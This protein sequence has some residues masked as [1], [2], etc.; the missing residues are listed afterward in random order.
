MKQT[1]MVTG[2]AG[3]V[4]SALCR[5]LRGAG[6]AVVAVVRSAQDGAHALGSFDAGTDFSGVLAGVDTVVHLA[7]RVHVMNDSEA[8]QLGAYRAA[9]VDT[10]LALARQA[11]ACGVRRFVFASSLKVNGEASPLRPFGAA[12]APAPADPYGQSK[13]E[14]ELGLRALAAAS[15]MELVIVRPPLVYGPGVKANF[16]RLME[17]VRRGLPLPLASV[18]N[19]RSMVALDN[20]VDLLLVCCSHPQAPGHT[21]LVS[22]GHDLSSAELVRLIAAAMGRPAR[23]LPVPPALLRAGAAVL[24]KAAL[25]Q[26]LLDSLQVDIDA[27][28]STLGWTPP[29][30][31]EEGVRRCVDYFLKSRQEE[32]R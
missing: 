29:L 17:L 1:V 19:R 24:G 7:A 11:A 28:R 22:D 10:T 27:T 21:F 3:F 4:G 20:L 9:N 12:D 23:L 25:A 32:P 15:G 30:R 5:Q 14:A 18:R 2:A 13:H 16:L 6:A 26:R 31:P 8:D